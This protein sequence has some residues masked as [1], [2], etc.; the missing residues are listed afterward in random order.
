MIIMKKIIFILYVFLSVTAFAQVTTSKIQGVVSEGN[1]PLFGASVVAKHNPTGT[2]SGTMTQENG[3]YSIT[4]LRVGGPYTVTISY[5]G[6][7]TVEYSDIYW[8]WEKRL[9]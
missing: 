2:V 7:K 8:N 5:V 1:A 6:F 3:N 9:I 4:N